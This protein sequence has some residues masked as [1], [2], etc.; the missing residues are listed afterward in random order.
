MYKL[1]ILFFFLIT[2]NSQNLTTTYKITFENKEAAYTLQIKEGNL[3]FENN[4]PDITVTADEKDNR[5]ANTEKETT[6]GKIYK[7]TKGA[8]W[9]EGLKIGDTDDISISKIGD[10]DGIDINKIG[11]TDGIDIDREANPLLL[12]VKNHHAYEISLGFEFVTV[13]EKST[14]SD[15]K[16]TIPEKGLYV[17]VLE[18]EFRLFE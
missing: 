17:H 9:Q 13:V 5:D 2:Y 3:V 10:T 12:E 1:T 15:Q 6:L 18:N 16:I 11:E 7:I 14:K 8:T 4:Q